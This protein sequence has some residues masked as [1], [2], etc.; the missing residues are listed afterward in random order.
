MNKQINII[1]I[2]NNPILLHGL[3]AVFNSHKRCNVILSIPFL[4]QVISWNRQHQADIILINNDS[5]Q[6]ESLKILKILKR[7]QPETGVIIYNIRNYDVFIMKALD[8]GVYGVLSAK[9]TVYE[10]IEAIQIVHAR[11]KFISPDIAQII[12]LKRINQHENLDVH[13]LLSTRELEIMLLI[14]QGASVKEIA[15]NLRLSTKTV[16]TYRYRMFGK[17]NIRSDVE[18]THIAINNGLISSK[19]G[20]LGCQNSLNQKHF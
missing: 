18:L 16:N 1:I 5:C 6:F 7:T 17:L 19:Q 14:T 20:L 8:V 12:A 15:Q 13:E 3:D 2:D 10:L 9:I 4:E 11:R